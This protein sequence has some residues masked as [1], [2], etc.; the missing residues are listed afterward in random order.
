[1]F[2]NWSGAD[3]VIVVTPEN[4]EGLVAKWVDSYQ[5]KKV[6]QIVC[7]GA[8]RQDSVYN[9]L[10]AV[11][12]E[13]DIVL[14][15]DGVR[16]LVTPQILQCCAETASRTGAAIAAVPVKDTIKEANDK[17]VIR[18]LNRNRL[19]AVQTPQGFK[20]DILIK[21]MEQAKQDSFTGTDEASLVE[22]VNIPVTIVEGSYENIKITTPEDLLIAEIFLT[23][24][25][26]AV[27]L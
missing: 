16:P 2:E 18:T 20:K 27:P 11:G 5:L 7:G 13:I 1:M 14:V 17:T 3:E 26:S 8:R 24:N 22:R 10:K 21:A 19:W 4:Y 9:G 25:S 6:R 12:Q 23:R 15:H